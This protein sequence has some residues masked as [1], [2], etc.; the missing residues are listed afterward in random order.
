MH[1]IFSRPIVT[2]LPLC[3][4][5]Q[6]LEAFIMFHQYLF[7]SLTCLPC[8]STIPLSYVSYPKVSSWIISVM[9]LMYLSLLLRWMPSCHLGALPCEM[10]GRTIACLMSRTNMRLDRSSE[11]KYHK[12]LCMCLCLFFFLPLPWIRGHVPVFPNGFI[13]FMNYFKLNRIL[14]PSRLGSAYQIVS[15]K[16]WQK[17]IALG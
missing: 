10:G 14:F 2:A 11:R 3:L 4:S 7:S 12:D 1:C 13:L 15:L 8:C 17:V 5:L 6:P 16:E 9:I